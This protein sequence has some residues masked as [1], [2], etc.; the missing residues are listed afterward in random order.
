MYPSAAASEWFMAGEE[1]FEPPR[2]GF[3]ARCLTAWLLP[4]AGYAEG[5]YQILPSD[6]TCFHQC[7]CIQADWRNF[8]N[9]SKSVPLNEM[10]SASHT[11]VPCIHEAIAA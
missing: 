8:P 10:K 1:G 7:R 5:G 9:L 2:D 11:R 6:L 3:R 4:N